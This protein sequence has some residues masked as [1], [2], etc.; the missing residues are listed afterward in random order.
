MGLTGWMSWILVWIPRL[1]I[2][3]WI[4]K[5]QIYNVGE[6]ILDNIAELKLKSGIDVDTSIIQYLIGREDKVDI[7]VG[8]VDLEEGRETS[9]A[10]VRKRL[11]LG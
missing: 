11:S 8:M 5:Q 9:L 1:R 7:R 4:R 6:E 3:G 10:E 2:T